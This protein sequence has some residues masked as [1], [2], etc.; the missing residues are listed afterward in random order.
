MQLLDR[1][2]RL[3]EYLTSGSAIF[4]GDGE[5][6]IGHPLHGIDGRLLRLE[7]QF[8]HQ[9]R[10]EKIKSVFPITFRL[11]DHDCATMVGEFA[12]AFPPAGVARIENAQ[13]FYDFLCLRWQEAPPV[14]PYLNDV[15]A[16]EFAIA[17][18]RSGIAASR[19]EPVG[20]KPPR[21][22]GIRRHP[23][24]AL[25]RCGYDIRPIFE[26]ASKGAAPARRD[27]PLAIALP[28]DAEH[29]R[30][31]EISALVFQALEMLD[32]WTDRS[33]LGTASEVGELID[34]LARHGLVEVHS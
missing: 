12:R 32:D 13:Q 19:A 3:L 21:R 29:P 6:P 24:V 31:F 18:V 9:K 1:Q 33:E 15:A 27:T 30:I 10:M 5:A 22:G 25:F 11:L 26:D 20:G 8:S 2:V 4:G 14:P 17:R 7:A 16:C 28:P 34:E 23:E